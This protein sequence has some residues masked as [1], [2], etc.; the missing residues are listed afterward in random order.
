MEIKI[1]VDKL[2]DYMEDYYGTAA[3]N[4]SPAA[5]VDAWDVDEA[6]PYELCERA[7]REG[8]DLTR[9]QKR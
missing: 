6:D 2:R 8:I 9:F 1:D 5:M 3:F 7:E 4:G